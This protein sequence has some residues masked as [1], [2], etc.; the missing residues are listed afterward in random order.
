MQPDREPY[1]G[2]C[3]CF[4]HTRGGA[5]PEKLY[6][7]YAT[8][9]VALFPCV[10]FICKRTAYTQTVELYLQTCTVTTF[11]LACLPA[12]NGRSEE[13]TRGC[14]VKQ[15]PLWGCRKDRSVRH[16]T[17]PEAGHVPVG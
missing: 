13:A 7:A 8:G 9:S 17:G 2:S 16:D 12:H 5:R 3:R 10:G 4:S 6:W 14:Y 11:I 15:E 1:C